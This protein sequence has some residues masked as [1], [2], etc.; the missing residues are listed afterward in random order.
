MD[1]KID[2]VNAL[3][4]ELQIPEHEIIMEGMETM[5]HKFTLGEIKMFELR[6][7]NYGLEILKGKLERK[8]DL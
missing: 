8:R 6:Q 2:E 4:E 1:I 5:D 3:I 7:F